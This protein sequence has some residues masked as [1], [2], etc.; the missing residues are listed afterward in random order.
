MTQDLPRL[1]RNPTNERRSHA[2]HDPAWACRGCRRSADGRGPGGRDCLERVLGPL[3]PAGQ[4]DELGEGAD[5][6]RVARG[7]DRGRRRRPPS[8][9]TR[10]GAAASAASRPSTRAACGGFIS[11]LPRCGK[12]YP[13]PVLEPLPG[14][15]GLGR[16]R[17]VA[18][19]G[20]AEPLVDFPDAGRAV[21]NARRLV[22]ES[23]EAI[24]RRGRRRRGRRTG[25]SAASGRVPPR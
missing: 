9:R 22:E 21:A 3:E 18:G 23:V 15:P 13:R 6:G 2:Q 19:R 10:P 20:R 1:E 14:R 11:G 5:R 24:G 12:T 25:R 17:D 8:T 4:H 16:R 7:P